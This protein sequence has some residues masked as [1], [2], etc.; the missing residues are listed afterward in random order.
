MLG[1][2][3]TEDYAEDMSATY[4]V[5]SPAVEKSVDKAIEGMRKRFPNMPVD[6]RATVDGVFK[7]L[8]PKKIKSISP[9]DMLSAMKL[10]Y[11]I[12]ERVDRIFY[13]NIRSV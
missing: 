11:E 10:L 3:P 2:S 13:E 6:R 8:E 7:S 9:E 1:N 5:L 4:R 12:D